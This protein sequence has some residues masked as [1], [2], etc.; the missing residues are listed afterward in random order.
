MEFGIQS[1]GSCGSI[2]FYYF[3][4]S[5]TCGMSASLTTKLYYKPTEAS[6]SPCSYR[7]NMHNYSFLL[8]HISSKGCNNTS[9]KL[10]HK[11]FSKGGKDSS[12]KLQLKQ[13]L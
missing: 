8:V 2:I 12:L 3:A 13:Y 7:G 11:H 1:I 5:C 9:L 6:E 10:E 4:Q